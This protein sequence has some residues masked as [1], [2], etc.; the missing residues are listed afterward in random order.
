[1][2]SNDNAV[3]D[4]IVTLVSSELNDVPLAS[5]QHLDH[6]WLYRCSIDVY[7]YRYTSSIPDC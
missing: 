5:F 2:S 3:Y 1:M 7:V 6:S 4:Y